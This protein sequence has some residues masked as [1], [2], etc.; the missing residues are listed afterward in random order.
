MGKETRAA[1]LRHTS[2][3]GLLLSL[4]ALLFIF[5]TSVAAAGPE[6]GQD[7]KL[8]RRAVPDV[9]E[10]SKYINLFG[11]AAVVDDHTCAKGR[12]CING[13]CCGASGVCGYGPAYCGIGCTSNCDAKAECGQFSEDGKK[14]CPLNVC[15]SQFGFCGRTTEFCDPGAGCQSNCGQPTRP[16]GGGNVRSQIIGYYESWS[17]GSGRCGSLKPSQLPVSALDI[18]NFAFA[19]ISPDTLDIVP[20]VGEDGSSLSA[21]D[22]D[23][24]YTAVTSARFANPKTGFWLSIGGWTFSDNNTEFQ[25]VFGDM[26]AEEGFRNQFALNLVRFMTQY[27]FDGVDIDWEY[28]GAPD[29]GGT[30]RDFGNFPLLLKAVRDAFNEHGHGHWGISITAPSSYWYLQ[31]FDLQELVKHVNFINLMSYDLH[32]I[33]DET[34]EIGKQILAHTNL[35]EVDQALDLFWLNDISPTMINLGI[36]FYGRSYK[37]ADASCTK[38][39]CRFSGPGAK[40]DC[41]NT[42][43]YLSY[44]EI[45]EEVALAGDSAYQMWDREAAVKMFVYD[46][47]NWISYDDSVTFQ[48]K[49]DFANDRGLAGLMVWA[50]DQDDDGFNA[51]KALTNREVDAK[52]PESDSLDFDISQCYYTECG[53][54]CS[55]N[56]GFKEMT[57][58][59]LDRYGKGC[60]KSGKDS[61]QRALCCPP[62]GA[63][64]P[65]TCHWTNSCTESCEDG[66]TTLA[67]DNYGGGGYCS[68]NRKQFCCPALNINKA[69]NKCQWYRGSSCPSNKPQYLTYSGSSKLCCPE[70]PV[71]NTNLCDWYGSSGFCAQTNCPVGDVLVARSSWAT[72]VKGSSSTASGCY[73][74]GQKSFCCVSPFGSDAGGTLPVPL[75]HLFPEYESIPTADEAVYQEAFD[76]IWSWDVDPETSPFAWVVMVGPPESVQSLDRRDGSFLETFDCPNPDPEDYSVQTFKAVCLAESD[77]HD[78]EDLL[79]GDGAYGTIAR[80]PASCGPDEWVRVVS[81]NEIDNTTLPHHLV[82]RAT[83]YSKVYEIKYDYR[84]RDVA[85]DEI[86]VRIDTSSHAHYWSQIVASDM[87]S[88]KKRSEDDLQTDGAAKKKSS[89]PDWREPHMEWF[90][91]HEL[92]KRGAGSGGWWAQKFIDLLKNGAVSSSEPG[93]YSFEQ[94]L[95]QASISC[96]PNFDAS[97]SVRANGSLN[98]DLDFGV[99][100]I[101]RVKDTQFEQA[102]A[103]FSIKEFS[104]NVQLYLEGEAQFTFESREA[105]LLENFAPWGGSFNIKGLVTIGPYMDVTAQVDSIATVSGFFGSGVTISNTN[106]NNGKTVPL[107][108]MYPPYLEYLPDPTALYAGMYSLDTTVRANRKVSVAAQGSIALTLTPSIAFKV[109]VDINGLLR[110]DTHITAAFPNRMTIGVGTSETCTNGLQYRMDYEQKFDLITNTSSLGWDLPTTTI[111]KTSKQLLAPKCYSFIPDNF[112]PVNNL[113]SRVTGNATQVPSLQSVRPRADGDD[114]APVVNPLFP[115]PKGSCLVCP[116]DTYFEDSPCSPL[117]DEDGIVNDPECEG[118]AGASSKKRATV[119]GSAPLRPEYEATLRWFKKERALIEKRT[120]TKPPFDLCEKYGYDPAQTKWKPAVNV[121]K[122]TYYVSSEVIAGKTGGKYKI[123]GPLDRSD[124]DNYEFGELKTVSD[125]KKYGAEHVLEHQTLKDFLVNFVA[126]M[127]KPKADSGKKFDNAATPAY[128]KQYT[129]ASDGW[130]M[131][132]EWGF[133]AHFKFWL[134]MIPLQA[135]W[136]DSKEYAAPTGALSQ[137]I[138]KA[139]PNTEKYGEEMPLLDSQTNS[140]KEAAWNGNT[141]DVRRIEKCLKRKPPQYSQAI[142]DMREVLYAIQYHHGIEDILKKQANRIVD[143]LEGMETAAENFNDKTYAV[144]PYVRVDIANYFKRWMYEESAAAG[145]RMA[146]VLNQYQKEIE[147]TLTGPSNAAGGGTTTGAQQTNKDLLNRVLDLKAAYGEVGEWSYLGNQN[148][149]EDWKDEPHYLGTLTTIRW[150]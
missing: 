112:T 98:A 93:S 5:P 85:S 24:L 117:F 149:F 14:T 32:G 88:K 142:C 130:L 2:I 114:Q 67:L 61:K 109:Q 113:E 43:G 42:A 10:Q 135:T 126:F 101:G 38:P 96:P 6:I 54:E 35:T 90:R 84:I 86:F 147:E 91:Q 28:P 21:A 22:A 72:P 69:V 12:P 36:A 129:R 119:P 47:D 145:R 56:Q 26:A 23:K 59:N 15:C 144:K 52:V 16:G 78:C 39:G 74:G 138:M 33:W 34:N 125:S 50:V 13:A 48:Q 73:F 118:I 83:P 29:R 115:D 79:L 132:G 116:R 143:F 121:P 97:M 87:Q 76:G 131:A 82:K 107:T 65:A 44:R 106:M 94:V 81:F 105:Q 64:D 123:Y 133:C 136:Y 19:Y 70:E 77:D 80:L 140:V 100:L 31:Y 18:V 141:I 127:N 51:L 20:M 55:P 139:I 122:L 75:D 45:M 46:S 62:W 57:R 110:T 120:N 41:S 102:F 89:I 71:F 8:T 1:R 63:P 66:E 137:T 30:D 128:A 104:A 49:V 92:R 7:L 25:H 99:S 37:L 108:W 95:Y 58:L 150:I 17:S 68:T 9:G 53:G 124:M 148:P 60:P 11:R 4:A 146:F 111:Y 103:Y 27:G 3:V 40:G 134:D